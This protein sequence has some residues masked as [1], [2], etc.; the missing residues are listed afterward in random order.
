[1]EDIRKQERLNHDLKIVTDG[2][3][4]KLPAP[5]IA[6][7]LC[8]GYGRGEG[9]WF[10][11]DGVLQPYNDYDIM[12]I[13]DSPLPRSETNIL[14][15][16][17]ASKVKI[18][19]VDISYVST[20]ELKALKPIIH[21]ADLLYASTLLYGDKTILNL[22]PKIDVA[23]LS[24]EDVVI[25]YKTR[26]WTLLGSWDGSFRALSK[27]E[28]RYFKNQMAKAV[29]AS[30]DMLLIK[31]HLYTPSYV[32]RVKVIQNTFPQNRELCELAG[33]AINEKLTPSSTSL[34][35]EEM[36][37][38]YTKVRALFKESA[39]RSL[40]FKQ[41]FFMN[42]NRTKLYFHFS[43]FLPI[44]LLVYK[45][46]G[47]KQKI[48]KT[49]DVFCAQNYVFHSYSNTEANTDYL[50]KANAILKKWGYTDKC[51][52]SWDELRQLAAFA[53]NNI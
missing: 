38:L 46:L 4:E 43:T 45:I 3:L 42:P 16:E 12:V 33:W 18:R 30:C 41:K 5:P 34:S 25:L 27:E 26:I 8:G 47:R 10:E 52:H 32:E 21:N 28:S 9:A 13:T 17:L 1:M 35:K 11:E 36:I 31:R 24:Q 49:I 19:W 2:I 51:G 29:L 44:R 6:I 7:F 14:R 50:A 48:E 23:K 22:A 37:A 53:R 39:I 15:K 20:A 40:G